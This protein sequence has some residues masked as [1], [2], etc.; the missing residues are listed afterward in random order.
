M[1][2]RLASGVAKTGLES[3][4]GGSGFANS[5]P[6]LVAL[7]SCVLEQFKIGLLGSRDRRSF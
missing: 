5:G 2:F 6:G 4:A 7:S 1:G 3:G